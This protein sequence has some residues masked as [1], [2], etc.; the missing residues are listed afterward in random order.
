MSMPVYRRPADHETFFPRAAGGLSTTTPMTATET[1]SLHRRNQNRHP[2]GSASPIHG[3]TSRPP[4]FQSTHSSHPQPSK[5][6][7]PGA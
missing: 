7:S 6:H 1:H 3:H 4:T 5:T 2:F